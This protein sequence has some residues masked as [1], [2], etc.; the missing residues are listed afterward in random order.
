[1]QFWQL[2]TCP[3]GE[4]PIVLTTWYFGRPVICIHSYS[5]SSPTTLLTMATPPAKPE[6]LKPYQLVLAK[7]E[8]LPH[9]PS[10][11]SYKYTPEMGKRW[12][13]VDGAGRDKY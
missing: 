13:M 8:D 4:T 5:Y 12:M 7:L 1:M 6:W 11:I 10:V 9:V 3:R 2:Y